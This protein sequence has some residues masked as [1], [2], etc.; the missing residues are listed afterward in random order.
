MRQTDRILIGWLGIV[1]VRIIA[2]SH[3]PPVA[4]IAVDGGA[5]V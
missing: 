4:G 5:E 2:L 1:A 3:P